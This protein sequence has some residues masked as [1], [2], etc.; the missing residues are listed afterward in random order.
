VLRSQLSGLVFLRHF[1]APIFP[2]GGERRAVFWVS[3]A[4]PILPRPRPCGGGYL[5][6][7]LTLSAPDTSRGQGDTPC[8]QVWKRWRLS[9]A[10]QSGPSALPGSG[11]S[12]SVPARHRAGASPPTRMVG[13][14]RREAAPQLP[15]LRG[16]QGSL[17]AIRRTDRR[18]GTTDPPVDVH[19]HRFGCSPMSTACPEG[20][21]RSAGWAPHPTPRPRPPARAMV[22]PADPA[23]P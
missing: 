8:G 7:L 13:A 19:R 10:T 2:A 6:G 3:P 1:R 23:A 15:S 14:G 4:L 22:A 21:T 17:R 18:E 16:R 9:Y 11:R 20:R 5:G 12:F